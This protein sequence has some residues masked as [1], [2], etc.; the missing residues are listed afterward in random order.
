MTGITPAT[1]LR[2]IAA[3]GLVIAWGWLAHAASA[4][5]GDSNLAV[6]VASAPL[7]AIVV[8]LLWRVG[9]KWWLIAGALALVGTLAWHWQALRHNV[10]LLYCLQHV[11]TNLALGL[12]FGRSLFGPGE[13]LVTRFARLAHHGVLSDAQLRY[14]RQVTIA[15][16]NC[17]FSFSGAFAWAIG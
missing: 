14:T 12:L 1:L 4:G 7:L 2:G 6:A 8:I 5:K 3:A 16:A 15:S 11:G 10:A 9:R 13:S 17:P